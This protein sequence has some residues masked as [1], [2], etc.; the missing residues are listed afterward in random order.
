MKERR[1]VHSFSESR[2]RDETHSDDRSIREILHDI[3]NNV[4][5]IVKS[6]I[7][8]ATTEVR[9]NAK[10]LAKAG[11]WIGVAAV[12]ALYA[13][14]FILL[15]A[16]Y[17]LQEVVPARLAALLVGVGV[18]IVAAILYLMGRKKLAQTSLTPDKTIQSL[19][20]NVTWVKKQTK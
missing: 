4:N 20:D 1:D 7:R 17:G 19:E 16:V 2:N 15:S 18:G 11:I 13:A 5:D 12:L 3:V 8:L 14:G 9:E 10:S 6:E